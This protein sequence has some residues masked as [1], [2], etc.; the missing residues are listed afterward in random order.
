MISAASTW[1]R[2]LATYP[3]SDKTG[4]ETIHEIFFTGSIKHIYIYAHGLTYQEDVTNSWLVQSKKEFK[5]KDILDG[6]KKNTHKRKMKDVRVKRE[7][8]HA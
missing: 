6:S 3:I 1:D 8:Y 4:K 7:T 2:P 5:K